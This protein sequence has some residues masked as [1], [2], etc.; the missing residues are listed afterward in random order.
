MPLI[1]FAGI[2]S[3]IDSTSLIQATSNAARQARVKPFEKKVTELEETNSAFDELKKKLQDI[4]S[5]SLPFTTLA[6][7][8]LSKLANSGDETVV[9]GSASNS[10]TNSTY[11]VTVNQLAK[12]AT[13]SWN[14]SPSNIY[15]ST[16]D[17]LNSGISNGA[18]EADRTVSVTTGTGS[19]AETVDVVLTD[20]TTLSEF[21]EM[22]NGS[23]T[24]STA[25]LVNV[26]TPSDPSY[27]VAINS[28]EEG[29]DEG[30]IQDPVVG[31]ELANPPGAFQFSFTRSQA[32]DASINVSGIADPIVRSSNKISDVIPGVTFD[33]HKVGGPATISVVDDVSATTAKVQDFVD[34]YNKLVEFLADNN[35]VSREEDGADVE[36]I[37]SPLAKTRTDDN[38]LSALR[39]AIS[40]STYS[41]GSIV[42]IFADLGITT[43]RDGTLKFDADQ[44]QSAVDSEPN[45]VNEVLKS[46]GNTVAITN[47]VIDQYVRFNG[48]VDLSINGNKDQ[49]D[50]MNDRIAQAEASILRQEESMR[51]R[52]ARLES[53][54]GRLQSQ[55]SALT[56]ALASLG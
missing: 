33:I 26:G 24:K 56:S 32:V 21:V 22:Y 14:V 30:T 20:T 9:T 41:G 2:A 34:A 27:I 1:N 13:L 3:G 17:I 28:L 11:T 35:R 7:G 36:N 16:S 37:F 6:G 38:A 46:F 10:A 15:R 19:F 29:T 42:R 31:S 12:N 4:Q 23:A 18:P 52:F 48:L 40:G 43:E 47:G 44:F 53:L 54:T 45:S 25:S 5:L 8:A 55:Q 51:M 39:S 50:D 49:I